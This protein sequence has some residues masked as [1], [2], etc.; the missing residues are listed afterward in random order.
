MVESLVQRFDPQRV[1][2]DSLGALDRLA[3]RDRQRQ[4]IAHL[5]ALM[6]SRGI[7][8]L[9]TVPT[10]ATEDPLLGVDPLVA[11]GSDAIVT[12]RLETVAGEIRR[13]AS[14]P[15]LR[16]SWH[17]R[18]GRVCTIDAN[19][20]HIGRPAHGEADVDP[21]DREDPAMMGAVGGR[22]PGDA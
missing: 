8:A 18:R 22:F 15:K 14:V 10:Q 16:G 4:A 12:L 6:R 3:D 9:F 11:A 7:A 20:L 2:I 1:V 19:G 17:E 13:V 5:L 21:L